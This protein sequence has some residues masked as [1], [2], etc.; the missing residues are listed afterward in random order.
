MI[1]DLLLMIIVL[2]PLAKSVFIRWG[3]SAGMSV[4]DAAIQ[5]N[6]GSIGLTGTTGVMDLQEL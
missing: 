5:K 2:L 4:A 3:L 1:E 6:Y